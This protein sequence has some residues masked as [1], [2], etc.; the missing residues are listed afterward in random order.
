MQLI[1]IKEHFLPPRFI[2]PGSRCD[3][4]RQVRAWPCELTRLKKADE[5]RQRGHALDSEGIEIA[6]GPT[7][8]FRV[9]SPASRFQ[10]LET[11]QV[12]QS[13]DAGLAV[14]AN[15]VVA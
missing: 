6:R 12:S 7:K 2:A 13:D 1:G 14:L 4:R 15:L 9:R 3:F 5:S 11:L 8:P 10:A